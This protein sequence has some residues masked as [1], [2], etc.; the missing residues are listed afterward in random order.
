MTIT[1]STLHYVAET[2]LDPKMQAILSRTVSLP[3]VETTSMR[4][5]FLVWLVQEIL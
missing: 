3:W 4:P 2:C 1:K 5:P